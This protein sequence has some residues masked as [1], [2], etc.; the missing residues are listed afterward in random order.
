VNKQQI[1]HHAA[2]YYSTEIKYLSE[3]LIFHNENVPFR[4]APSRKRLLAPKNFLQY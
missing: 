1:Q 4:A 2:A 3:K